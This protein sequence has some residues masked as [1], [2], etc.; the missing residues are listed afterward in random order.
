MT[1]TSLTGTFPAS[2]LADCLAKRD[3]EGLISNGEVARIGEMLN[4][5]NVADQSVSPQ[6]EGV[7]GF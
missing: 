5:F 1:L 6:F 4:G 7:V 2:I 3:Y